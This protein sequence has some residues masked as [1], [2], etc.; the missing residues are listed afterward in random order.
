MVTPSSAFRGWNDFRFVNGRPQ[1]IGDSTTYA[2]VLKKGLFLDDVCFDSQ[3]RVTLEQAVFNTSPSRKQPTPSPPSNPD[4]LEIQCD[5]LDK[6]SVLSKR[7]KPIG[8]R[9]RNTKTPTHK[10]KNQIPTDNLDQQSKLEIVEDVTTLCDY[11]SYLNTDIIK[12]RQE[13]QSSKSTRWYVK[14]M[15][16]RAE[17]Q[18]IY[19]NFNL[20]DLLF[21]S[22]EARTAYTK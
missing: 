13:Y 8:R 10:P 1:Y 5:L 7:T 21:E 2:G 17:K 4:T 15:L 9:S 12:L 20:S 22:H 11:L 19:I 18:Y 14:R 16:K 6:T 3:Q